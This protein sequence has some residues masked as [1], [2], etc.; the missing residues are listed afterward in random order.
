[1][2]GF[3]ASKSGFYQ[4]LNG[5]QGFIVA[6]Q[7]NLRRCWWSRV[8]YSHQKWAKLIVLAPS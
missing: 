2:T 3:S 1:L 5:S 7:N 4:R 8:I 6:K